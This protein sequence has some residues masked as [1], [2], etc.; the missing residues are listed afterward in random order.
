MALVVGCVLCSIIHHVAILS[1][2]VDPLEVHLLD[3]PIITIIIIKGSKLQLPIQAC[4][5]MEKFTGTPVDTIL[6]EI[7]VSKQGE[8]IRNLHCS[9][10][11]SLMW[12]EVSC[13]KWGGPH[14][15]EHLRLHQGHPKVHLYGWQLCDSMS[16]DQPA[17]YSTYWQSWRTLLNSNSWDG[18]MYQ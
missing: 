7:Y 6:F 17:Q 3:F 10:H 15:P 16:S 13:L 2:Y 8:Y 12:W 18:N 1:G 5:K 14:A 11:C 9:H 4:M